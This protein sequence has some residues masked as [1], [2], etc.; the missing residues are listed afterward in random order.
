MANST[1]VVLPSQRPKRCPH[2]H[3]LGKKMACKKC[4]RDM[5]EECISDHPDYGPVCGLCYDDLTDDKR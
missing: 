1:P 5:C 4:M 3:S 2:C